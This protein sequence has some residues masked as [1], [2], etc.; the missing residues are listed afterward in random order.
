MKQRRRHREIPK[1]RGAE[2]GLVRGIARD[3]FQAEIFVG[4]GPIEDH[5]PG[6]GA[7]PWRDLRHPDDVLGEIAEHLVWL[8]LLTA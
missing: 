5:V 7:E 4:T 2:F 8:A 1:R 6:A 3:L